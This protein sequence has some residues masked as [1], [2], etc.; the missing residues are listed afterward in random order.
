MDKQVVSRGSVDEG[1]LNVRRVF[2]YFVFFCIFVFLYFCIFVFLYLAG[3]VALRGLTSVE[4]I[5]V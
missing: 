4:S 3:R 5:A 1:T 2:V